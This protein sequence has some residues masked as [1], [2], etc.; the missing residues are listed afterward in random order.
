MIVVPYFI[1]DPIGGLDAPGP[2]HLVSPSL[3]EGTAQAR[4]GVLYRAL[5]DAV[6]E[7]VVAGDVPLVYAGDCLAAIGVL[8]GVQQVGLDPTLVWFDAH[9]DFHTWETTRSGFLGG[10]PL[11][12]IVG[13]GER[14]IVDAAGLT[15]VPEA[16]VALV[17][18]RDLD[19]GEDTT[20]AGS[21]M[22]VLPVAG[23]GDWVPPEG[24]IHLHVDLDVVDPGEMPAHN[25][26]APG[27]PSLREVR[28]AL[29]HLASSGRVAAVSFSTWNPARPGAD[30]AAAAALELAA[31]FLASGERG[32]PGGPGDPAR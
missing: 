22:T 10:M 24:P 11:A 26:P 14:T 8:A 32:G 31:P 20:V 4:M 17:G 27:G 29:E 25:Y 5:A 28:E 21:A 12:M 2:A 30:V 19:P 1:A 7:R 16:R 23:V 3:P 6:A 13:R 9:G 15:P 18:A